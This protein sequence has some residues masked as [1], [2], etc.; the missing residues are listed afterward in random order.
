MARRVAP[1][2]PSLSCCLR[3]LP[4]PHRPTTLHPAL[5][6]QVALDSNISLWLRLI[7]TCTL[8]SLGL[9]VAASHFTHVSAE[10]RGA[11][12]V[13]D[14]LRRSAAAAPRQTLNA[15][16]VPTSPPSAARGGSAGEALLGNG[17][18]ATDA[19]AFA[20]ALP[21]PPGYHESPLTLHPSPVDPSLGYVVST[22]TTVEYRVP[23]IVRGEAV[24]DTQPLA[25][26]RLE[27]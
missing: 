6:P 20:H 3:R 24:Y 14:A 5:L 21:A 11:R 1:P 8:C 2:R 23:P 26:G 12:R 25:T 18:A 16:A 9:F 10:L 7:S 15:N 13:H 19:T 17:G 22:T 4:R 27:R